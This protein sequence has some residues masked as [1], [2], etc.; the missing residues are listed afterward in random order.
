[1]SA[2]SYNTHRPQHLDE[3]FFQVCK[4]LLFWR[5]QFICAENEWRWKIN[6]THSWQR[7]SSRHIWKLPYLQWQD[8][9]FLLLKS[10]PF[11]VKLY[12]NMNFFLYL[13]QRFK[14]LIMFYAVNHL[15]LQKWI[16]S[17]STQP[18]HIKKLHNRF[19]FRSSTDHQIS[20][21]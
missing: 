13:P 18:F 4:L 2:E 8:A 15:H 11:I 21:N 6:L 7:N 1:M 19:T 12:R 14:F 17:L 9:V 3:T 10:S 5:I 20:S 16:W